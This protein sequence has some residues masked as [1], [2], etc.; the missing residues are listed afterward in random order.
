MDAF[1][2]LIGHFVPFVNQKY[3]RKVRISYKIRN[4]LHDLVAGMVIA[5]KGRKKRRMVQKK[6]EKIVCEHACSH[7]ACNHFV[8]DGMSQVVINTL[9]WNLAHTDL[10]SELAST[11]GCENHEYH[12]F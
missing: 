10:K 12:A 1:C 6:K 3:Y 7:S 11:C 9:W 2:S 4:L 8:N 5:V